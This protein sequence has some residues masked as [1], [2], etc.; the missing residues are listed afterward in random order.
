MDS[1]ELKDGYRKIWLRYDNMRFVA[2]FSAILAGFGFVVMRTVPLLGALLEL[3]AF[4]A[5]YFFW[6][7]YFLTPCPRCSK[8]FADIFGKP[9]KCQHCGHAVDKKSE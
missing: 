6:W 9:K 3:T 1:D 4:L 2:I 7:R 5:T 8:R